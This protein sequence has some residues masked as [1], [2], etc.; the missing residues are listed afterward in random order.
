VSLRT[1]EAEPETEPVLAPPPARADRRRRRVLAA[2]RPATW[3]ARLVLLGILAGGLALRLYNNEHGLPYV[4]HPDEAFHFTNRAV[5]SIVSGNLDPRYYQNPSG[6]TEL[7][8]AALRFRWGH[9]WPWGDF[10][11]FV[12]AYLHDPSSVYHMARVLTALLCMAGVLAVYGVGRRL[13]GVAEG[14]AAAA[15]L[16]FAFLPVAYSRYALTDVGVLV[17]VALAVY[18]IVRI[19]EDGRMRYYLLAGAASGLAIGFKYTAGVIVV[20]LLVA[21]LP[22]LKRERRATLLGVG[23]ALAATLVAFFLTTPYFFF[24]LHDALLQLRQQNSAA[25]TAK[26]GQDANNPFVFYFSSLT[27][28]L[29]WGPALAAAVGLVVELRRDRPRGVLLALM[30][31]VLILYMSVGAGRWFARWLMPIYP[32]LALLAGVGFVWLARRIFPRRPVLAAGA[33]AVIVAGA[34]VQPLLADVHTGRVLGKADTRILMR[35]YLFA[36]F[37]RKTR[38]V[39]DP[40]IPRY[41]FRGHFAKGFGPP[42]KTPT[43]Q[44]GTPTR[45][46]LSRSPAIIE[47]YRKTGHCVVV[48][49]SAVRDRAFLDHMQGAIA[50]YDA[51]PRE[52]KLIF[53]ASPYAPGAKPVPFN[54]DFSTTLFLPSAYARPG[55]DINI[56]RLNRC[57]QQYGHNAHTD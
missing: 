17:W 27:W 1:P 32:V 18:G 31:A 15:V 47:R 41:F 34:L 7:I 3:P 30:P 25:T 2:V 29:G 53:R 26:V 38:L 51:L 40:A 8:Y 19:R 28:A 16:S 39:V 52:G 12:Q 24:N 4:F 42:P 21:A 22:R 48:S 35:S 57:R 6:L 55:P 14:L 54:F 44:W 9:G 56:Y 23:A 10:H 11:P 13:W 33:L 36:H 49:M 46:L 5:H 50:Y 37:P 20:P 45:Y 43:L